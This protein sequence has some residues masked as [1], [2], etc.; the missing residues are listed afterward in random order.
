M[1]RGERHGPLHTVRA[2]VD[3]GSGAKREVIE[4][5]LNEAQALLVCVLS[6]GDEKDALHQI[7]R[8]D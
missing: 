3:G 2:I 8:P 1:G 7:R 6:R 5:R 4:Y